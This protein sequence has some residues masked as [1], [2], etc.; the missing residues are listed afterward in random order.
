MEMGVGASHSRREAVSSRLMGFL[1]ADVLPC[2]LAVSQSRNNRGD[3]N[4]PR[5]GGARDPVLPEGF[6]DRRDGVGGS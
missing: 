3:A 1:N 4:A 5:R 6:S 2:W